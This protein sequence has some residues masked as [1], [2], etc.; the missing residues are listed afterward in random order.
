MIEIIID[1]IDISDWFIGKLLKPINYQTIYWFKQKR[2][3]HY[4]SIFRV[5]KKEGK[6]GD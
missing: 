2:P 6:I 3:G 4:T 1:D 5:E